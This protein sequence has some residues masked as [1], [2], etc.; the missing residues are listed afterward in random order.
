MKHAKT[1]RQPPGIHHSTI[2]SQMVTVPA[3]SRTI[4]LG[5]QNASDAEGNLVG[6]SDLAAQVTQIMKN[7]EILLAS[8]EAGFQDLIK[9]TIYLLAGTD[10]K[11]GFQA[12]QDYAGQLEPPPL[13]TVLFVTGFARPGCLVEIDG[14][15]VL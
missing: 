14:I 9:L 2:Y 7:I 1:F 10:A 3:G 8:E 13:I 15:A 5:G 4:Y 12:Y 11:A 6:G